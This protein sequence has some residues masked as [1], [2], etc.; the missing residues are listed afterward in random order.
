MRAAEWDERLFKKH[1][2]MAIISQKTE[3][4]LMPRMAGPP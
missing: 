3:K 1:M 4:I 2:N